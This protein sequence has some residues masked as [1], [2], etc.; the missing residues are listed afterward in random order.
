MGKPLLQTYTC[1]AFGLAAEPLGISSLSKDK[2]PGTHIGFVP[3]CIFQE[4]FV[5]VFK[6]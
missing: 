2:A 5:A 4:S 1:T 6:S 3:K